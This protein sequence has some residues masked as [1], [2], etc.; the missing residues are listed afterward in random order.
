MNK[1]PK[2]TEI[3][4]PKCCKIMLIAKEEISQGDTVS[5]DNF[6]QVEFKGSIGTKMECPDC[7]AAFGEINFG[8]S[9]LHTKKG[10]V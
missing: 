6:E 3:T 1:L 7:K 10:W 5:S 8:Y 9:W 2:G 4:C